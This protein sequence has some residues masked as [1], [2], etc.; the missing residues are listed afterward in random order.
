MQLLC[1]HFCIYFLL[2]FIYQL[3]FCTAPNGEYSKSSCSVSTIL[4][5]EFH[6]Y[7]HICTI[8]FCFV[9]FFFPETLLEQYVT[10]CHS[11]CS[12]IT[13]LNFFAH[14]LYPVL[15]F[16]MALFFYTALLFSTDCSLLCYVLLKSHHFDNG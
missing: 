3:C 12:V 4:L 1:L 10:N 16:Y 5:F 15:F 9:V 7:L 14:T 13:M 2:S 6:V 11:T 8:Y